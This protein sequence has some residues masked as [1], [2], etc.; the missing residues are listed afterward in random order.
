ML[1]SGNELYAT[2]NAR[3]TVTQPEICTLLR[4]C[5]RIVALSLL[6]AS[7][8]G[9]ADSTGTGDG[10][11]HPPETIS[12]ATVVLNRTSASATV[13]ETVQLSAT[14]RAADGN[15][16]TGRSISWAS[17]ESSVA[18]VSPSGLVTALAPGTTTIR[19]TSEGKFAEA[20]IS[21]SAIAA[22][23]VELTVPSATLE[24]GQ[25]ST[26]IAT[27][28]SSTGAVLAGRAVS[29]T[30]SNTSAAT[31]ANGEVTAIAP[32]E[33]TISATSEGKA[34]NAVITVVA[35]RVAS[36]VLS[37]PTASVQVG[38]TTTLTATARAANN[39]VLNGRTI[40]WTSADPLVATVSNGVVTGIG[41]GNTT[42]T[43]TSEGKS[44]QATVTVTPVPVA[45]VEIE[46]GNTTIQVGATVILT[47]TTRS[48]AGATLNGRNISWNSSL[49]AVAT[50]A[51]GIVT[52]VAP[53]TTTITATSEGKEGIA[54]VTVMPPLQVL[55][56][57][58]T[59]TIGLSQTCSVSTAGK[60]FCWGRGALGNLG[61]GSNP[62]QQTTPVA[63]S[64]ALDFVGL[65]SG[66]NHVCGVASNGSGW[67]WGWGN[68]GALGNGSIEDRN[69]PV[70]ISGGR[71]WKQIAVSNAE[72]LSC[73]LTSTN[74]AFC[75]G[76]NAGGGLG[77]GSPVAGGASTP[78]PVA[79][80][81]EFLQID[82][83]FAGACAL[84]SSGKAWCWGSGTYGQLGN[85]S[86][87]S[88]GVPVEVSG[89]HSFI[90]VAAG[91]AHY[92]GL[93]A[94][95]SLWCWGFNSLGQLGDGST[96]DRNTPVQVLGGHSFVSVTGGSVTTC[97]LKANGEVWC[98]GTGI[99]GQ[100]GNG[101]F[102]DSQTTPVPVSGGHV[103]SQ[104][105][106]GSNGM[107]AVAADGVYCWGDNSYG[108]LG[109]G[110]TIKRNV[111]TRVIGLP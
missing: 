110:T 61:N 40:E 56:G 47:A 48:A 10:H 14:T 41:P 36:V 49:P 13:G 9:A 74:R 79:G 42:V 72:R 107:C 53:G 71:T 97:A 37:A 3:S 93:E 38:A 16:L 58:R 15:T 26:I 100:L 7:C 4:N 65:A 27:V 64:S 25:T 92:C 45:A 80:G 83:G 70:E 63:V 104:I 43:A 111:P 105:S 1:Q 75:W 18:S 78:Q 95:G 82:V 11:E 39:S 50:V 32:G 86:K 46:P 34:A 98:W 54:Q 94:N 60:V 101:T 51:D 68:T 8:K 85:G 44:A 88:S 66:F 12:V 106:G 29:W 19:A 77:I 57:K 35:V 55:D 91:Y 69:T 103:F 23:S 2:G 33:T 90:Q 76:S 96:T 21:V 102:S 81:R 30:S 99:S 5:S 24:V 109:D 59:V 73:G 52:A 67:C 31:V 22:A 108:M 20:V 17:S 89:N 28:R 84:T 6:L 87:T 62:E